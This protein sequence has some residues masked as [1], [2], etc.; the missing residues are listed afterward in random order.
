ML[1][2]MF[3][4]TTEKSKSTRVQINYDGSLIIYISDDGPS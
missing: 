1:D 3:K 2:S 4:C